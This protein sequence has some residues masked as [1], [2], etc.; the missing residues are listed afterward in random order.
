[1][2]LSKDIEKRMKRQQAVMQM[3]QKKAEAAGS[4]AFNQVDI[5]KKKEKVTDKDKGIVSP[6]I[7]YIEDE[8]GR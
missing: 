7:N 5:S 8:H 1:M 3:M 4:V 6:A 2:S